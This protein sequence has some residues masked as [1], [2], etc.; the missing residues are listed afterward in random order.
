MLLKNKSPRLI[1]INASVNPEDCIDLMP[2]GKA[3]D[4]PDKLC[5]SR[6]VKALLQTGSVEEVGESKST[7]DDLAG[8]TVGELK[9]YAEGLE[10]E[11]DANIKKADLKALIESHQEDAG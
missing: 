9:A 3:V 4:V 10:I 1:S 11:Y 5:I 7:G 8:L 2:A 6:Y